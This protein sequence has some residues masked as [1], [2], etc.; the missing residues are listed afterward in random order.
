MAFGEVRLVYGMKRMRESELKELLEEKADFY[1][2]PE[3]IGPD[4]ISVPHQFTKRQDVE[5]A[6]FFSAVLAWGQRKTIIR[7]SLEL[8]H[9]MDDAPYEFVCQHQEHDLKPILQFK[10][11]TFNPTDA[12]Y[13]ME[14][15]RQLYLEHGSLEPLFVPGDNESHVGPALERFHRAFFSLPDYPHRTEKHIPSPLRKSTCKRLNMFLRWM[16]RKDDRGVDF[17]IWDQIRP[18][19]LIC[20]LDLHVDRVA[21]KLRLIKRHATDWS[22]ALELTGNLLKLDPADPVKYD[23]A[24]FGLGVVEGFGRKA[25]RIL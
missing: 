8:M 4:P 5:I 24:L 22:T 12:L 11:R 6:G 20:P 2:R 15:L 10:H 16:A 17:G 13:F 18:S 14:A 7:K 3:F 1:N 23:F 21:R 19:H 9:L 25:V